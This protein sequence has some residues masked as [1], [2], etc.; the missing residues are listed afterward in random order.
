MAAVRGHLAVLQW[1][2]ANGCPWAANTCALAVKHGHLDVLQWAQ[3][4][5]PQQ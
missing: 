5:G 2:H 4:N 1:A 3:E